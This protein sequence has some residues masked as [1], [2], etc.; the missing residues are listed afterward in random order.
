MNATVNDKTI[1]LILGFGVGWLAERSAS[2]EE[3]QSAAEASRLF[4][5]ARALT[6]AGRY[7][8]ACPL[9]AE[10]EALEAHAGAM[11]NL[12]YC[13]ENIGKTASSWAWW[14]KAAVAYSANGRIDEAEVARARAGLL[15]GR[16]LR[17][18]V[19]VARQPGGAPIDV[20]LD[21]ERLPTAQWNT[22]TAVDP[23]YH[24]VEASA[25][26]KR[27]WSAELDVS[28]QHVPRVLVPILDDAP[29]SASEAARRRGAVVMAG[30]G[31]VAAATGAV[32]YGIAKATY[33]GASGDCSEKGGQPYCNSPG[34][35]ERTRGV[36]EFN[37]ASVA[38]VVGGAALAGATVLWFTAPLGSGTE[39]RAGA[40]RGAWNLSMR[41][42]W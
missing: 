14:L 10:S 2:A 38:L 35:E 42:H 11:V 34:L 24:T 9:F 3:S 20:R 36:A 18:V 31:I 16:L 5:H 25:P 17:V 39:V 1:A 22:A 30:A 27:R 40:E 37:I 15:E 12:A 6:D 8:E 21:G 32:L 7:A 33:D 41:G 29:V 19:A 26:G 13:Y 23:G 4:E 28:D